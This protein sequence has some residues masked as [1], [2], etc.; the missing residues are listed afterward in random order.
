[1]NLSPSNHSV[2]ER[3]YLGLLII[4][5]LAMMF[6][7]GFVVW[8][9]PLGWASVLPILAGYAL[10]L[11]YRPASWLA[12]LPA[13]LFAVDLTPWTGWL[14]VDETDI[15]LAVTVVVGYLRLA[16][17]PP[18]CRLTPLAGAL[19]LLFLAAFFVSLWRGLWPLLVPD[20]NALTDYINPY[21][22]LR[23]AKGTLW[24][25]LLLPLLRRT[26]A[27]TDIRRYLLPGLLIALALLGAIVFWE[28][29]TFT[30]LLDF[31][32]DYRATGP[33]SAMHTGGA[34]LDGALALLMPFGI[35]WLLQARTFSRAIFAVI[36]VG[37]G[38]YAVMATFSRGLYLGFGLS[39]AIIGLSLLSGQSH[40]RKPLWQFLLILALLGLTGYLLFNV[41]A[42]GGYRTL[43]AAL[44]LLISA[45]FVGSLRGQ[46][47]K[48][49][50]LTIGATLCLAI[51]W[52][53]WQGFAKGAYLAFGLAAIV[54]AVGILIFNSGKRQAVG[55]LLGMVGFVGMVVGAGWVAQHWGGEPALL[56]A[57]AAIGLACGL[58]MLN[59]YFQVWRWEPSTWVGAG[60]V[61][62]ILGMG[63]PITGNY[64][65]EER[66]SQ[67][68][69]DW[70][71]R[72]Q[73]WQAGLLIMDADWATALWGMG[74]GKFPATY[75]WKNPQG[76]LPGN[77]QYKI[78]DHN[79]FLRISGARY[80]DGF[81]ESL[82]IGQ[83]VKPQLHTLYTLSLDARAPGKPTLLNLALCQ[84][85]LLYSFGCSERSLKINGS[86][87]RHFDI[88]LN[89]LKFSRSFWRSQRTVQFTLNNSRGG[90]LLD[91]D[92]LRLI[93]SVTGVELLANG[94]FSQ[95][96]NRWF[97]TSDHHHLPW[98]VKNLW[99]NVFFDQGWVGVGLLGLLTLLGFK[100]AFF[101]FKRGGNLL[102]LA[103]LASLSGFMAVGLFDSLLDVPRLTLMYYLL[104]LITL[105]E[106]FPST[107][108]ISTTPA[109]DVP[110]A[111]SIA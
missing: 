77:F 75:F 106:P 12:V 7:L 13:T 61:A 43:A 23:V 26:L 20:F 84:K 45:L 64:Y 31:S 62:I 72:L 71:N 65:M 85:W 14:L 110:Y 18:I 52:L 2:V 24:A 76:E 74:I 59:F 53:L 47:P 56:S 33:F 22:G 86:D 69:R 60:L 19:L 108:T 81:G 83:R 48:F 10:I 105:I 70:E 100:R 11:W 104:L 79:V 63:I 58:V 16:W 66:L 73:H 50:Y 34:A 4:V 15:V 92:N 6:P 42:T 32:S 57:L 93:D 25:F 27:E 98:H 49:T 90:T 30:G 21:N 89:T 41:F 8:H 82:R 46:M 67:A 17:I 40:S 109:V 28:R 102:A 111:A 97:F 101:A 35:V 91:V 78:E 96:G 95:G 39:V 80:P 29:L 99:L 94:D 87:W 103:L 38:T 1:M 36:L 3:L 5:V 9:Y 88:P 107:G 68:P 55:A 37:L 54:W 44:G 51:E